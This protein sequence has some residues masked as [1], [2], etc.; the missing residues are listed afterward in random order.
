MTDKSNAQNNVD[1]NVVDDFG[2]E[3]KIFDQ[4]ALTNEELT[5]AFNEYFHIFP[6]ELINKNSIGFD[7]GCG[8]GRWAKLIAP[9]V[10]AL[11]CI[12]PSNL[13][14]ESARQN[15]KL[16]NNC[17]FECAS[18][19]TTNIEKGTQDFGYCLGVLHH[20]PDTKLALRDC[21]SKLKK[22]APFLLYLYYRFDN[23]PL[24]FRLVWKASDIARLIISKLPFALKLTVSQLIACLIYFPLAKLSLL[25]EQL[26]FNVIN[27]PLSTYRNKT[28]YFMRTDALD[29]F[30]TRLETRFTKQEIRKMMTAAGLEDIRFSDKPPFWVAVGIRS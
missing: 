20:I 30:G 23:K 21:T 11:T 10:K 14:L 25:L 15:L 3:W 6:F 16:L 9:K 4:K 24:W 7:M 13:A 28:F 26:G 2:K 29:R 22:G 18:V 8:S 17:V 1:S 12:D 27:I 5:L 19:A